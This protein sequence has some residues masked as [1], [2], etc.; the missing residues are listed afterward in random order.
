MQSGAMNADRGE[1]WVE[2]SIAQIEHPAAALVKPMQSVD[3]GAQ[4]GPAERGEAGRL[5][6]QSGADRVRLG[7]SLVAGR[8]MTARRSS[9]AT[10][11]PPTPAPMM[12]MSRNLP[13]PP[14]QAQR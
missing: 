12:A 10:A 8:P 1:I 3:R 13:M 7:E 9:V 11:R 6:H 4:S 14:P 2:I 5:Q